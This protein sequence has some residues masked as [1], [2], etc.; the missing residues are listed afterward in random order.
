[1]AGYS[2]LL[3]K[4][5]SIFNDR[6]DLEALRT[7]FQRLPNLKR[8]SI[9]DV[10]KGPIDHQL[11][12]GYREFKWF[13]QQSAKVLK[14]ILGPASW[15]EAKDE[16]RN[17]DQQNRDF[18][19]DFRGITNLLTAIK[20]HAP[21]L[22]HLSFGC[23]SFRLS[24]TIFN[25][26]EHVQILGKLA[27]QLISLKI[28]CQLPR[29]GKNLRE[30]GYISALSGILKEA[31]RLQSLS[32]NFDDSLAGWTNIF[33]GTRCPDLRILELGDWIVESQSFRDIVSA[34]RETLLELRLHNLDIS[35]GGSWEEV[36]EEVGR[37][38]RLHFVAIRS[39]SDTTG[40]PTGN[41]AYLDRHRKTAIS[42]MQQTPQALMTWAESRQGLV[43]AWN[44][45]EIRPEIDLKCVYQEFSVYT[46][47]G[48]ERIALRTD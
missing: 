45:K 13:F 18:Q 43:M 41:S 1:M 44:S 6:Q 17:I 30:L 28:D 46:L 4:Q 36:A 39:L 38:L 23:S 20:E 22:R 10:V 32:L 16:I 29:I 33:H 11:H 34:H 9:L 47:S 27:S 42:F 14:N 19:W 15:T 31:K 37:H 5:A 40:F 7:G 8:I 25:R 12:F 21:Q 48:S 35:D 2:K 24:T 26:Q 3:R